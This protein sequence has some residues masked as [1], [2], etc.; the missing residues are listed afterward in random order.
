MRRHSESHDRSANGNANVNGGSHEPLP[1][2]A[3]LPRVEDLLMQEGGAAGIGSLAKEGAEEHGG[4]CCR[5]SQLTD[6]P[7]SVLRHIA[8]WATVG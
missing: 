7:V 4:K 2:R 6:R 1:R 8:F 3:S 5:V